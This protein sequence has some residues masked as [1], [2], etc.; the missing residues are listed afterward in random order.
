MLNDYWRYSWIPLK[1][2]KYKSFLL[3]TLFFKLNYIMLFQNLLIKEREFLYIY[4]NRKWNKKLFL[5]SI[6]KK[7]FSIYCIV[8]VVMKMKSNKSRGI[9][10]QSLK[11]F[12]NY[13][14]MTI[15]CTAQNRL[16]LLISRRINQ[17]DG[18]NDHSSRRF[19]KQNND[20]NK[21]LKI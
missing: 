12:V 10:S 21:L 11:F 14:L 16:S 3:Q 15:I 8:V 20:N 7:P 4:F 5:L 17:L 6:F 9:F 13:L 1:N 19:G 18:A 2:V